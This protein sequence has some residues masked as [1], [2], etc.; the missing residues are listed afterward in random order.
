MFWT[1]CC[2]FDLRY[3]LRYRRSKP[4]MSYT[5]SMKTYD[6][7]GFVPVVANCTLRY[8]IRYRGFKQ[9]LHTILEG[10]IGIIRYRMALYDLVGQ[11]RLKPTI[12]PTMYVDD[13]WCDIELCENLPGAAAA[14]RIA[15]AR[16][17]L[18]RHR[19]CSPRRVPGALWPA[20][21]DPQSAR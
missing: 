7:V 19:C 11:Y 15:L 1:C 14:L 16:P 18:R 13:V 10:H 3:Y 12:I 8:G 4:T 2:H 20:V 6:I 21:N 9:I 5:I 17:S